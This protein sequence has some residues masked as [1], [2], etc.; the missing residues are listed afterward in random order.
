MKLTLLIFIF[1]ATTITQASVPTEEGLLKNLN[2]AEVLGKYITVRAM[3]RS[4][5]AVVLSEGSSP[6]AE[7]E[8][9]KPDFYKFIISIENP[10]V[11]SF[12]QVAY[13]S[14]QMLNSQILDV[15]YIPDLLAAIKKEKNQEISF[16]YSIYLML[17]T[18]YSSGV[19]AF[20]EK[21]GVQIVKN[22]NIL[23]AE[24]IKLL[25]AYKSYLVNNKG[26]GDATSPLNPTDPK[27]K[28]KVLELFR[29]NTFERLKN[30]ELVK[31]ENE[32]QWKVDWK[33]IK[34][35]FTNEER[36]LRLMEYSTGNSTMK[37]EANNY[38]LFNGINELPK[39]ITVKDTRGVLTT[40]QILGLETKKS[41][42]KKLTEQYEEAKKSI[43][44]IAAKTNYS[45]LF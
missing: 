42:D 37:I 18:N 16:F 19:E 36:R 28:S 45:F 22:V 3:M 38:V 33:N 17:T 44:P 31:V 7:M 13:S 6:G 34:G 30:I 32:F 20:L 21:S 39:N 25:K 27:N 43:S 40:I 5:P 14:A 11:I 35:Y 23:N 8:I 41:I 1:L 2:N 12:F 15:K 4:A 29:S 10:N 26:K 24:K 9:N